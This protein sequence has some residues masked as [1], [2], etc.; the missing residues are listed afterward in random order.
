MI[1]KFRII[2]EENDK[3]SM[4]IEVK[5]TQTFFDLHCAIQ[6]E[7]EWDNSQLASFFICNDYWEK[8]QEISLLDMS[9]GDNAK[10]VVMDMAIIGDYVKELRQKLIYVF[11]FFSDRY[12]FIELIDIKPE[13]IKKHFPICSSFEGEVPQQIKFSKTKTAKNLFI[14]E[15]ENETEEFYDETEEDDF[16]EEFDKDLNESEFYDD[17]R[18][19][20]DE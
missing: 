16:D 9:D 15:F 19:I 10:P 12:F 1:Y 14:N 20:E 5:S 11:D 8:E 17:D 13:S 6:D 18:K 2:F 4:N 3:F 7:A